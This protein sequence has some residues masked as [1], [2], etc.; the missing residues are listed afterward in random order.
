[1]IFFHLAHGEES[2]KKLLDELN[3]FNQHIKFTYEYSVENIP[4]PDLKVGL[5]DGKIATL[6]YM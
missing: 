4:F 2:L 3:G 5:K 1:M 6:T